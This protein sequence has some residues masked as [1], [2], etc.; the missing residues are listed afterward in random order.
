MRLPVFG[1]VAIVAL[2]AGC[3]K[4]ALTPDAGGSI[5]GNLGLGGAGIGGDLGLGGAGGGGNIGPGGSAST[6]TRK[7]DILFVIDDS[8]LMRLPQNNLL[9]NFPAMASRLMDPP[10]LPDLHLAVISSDMGAGDGSVSGCDS[11]GGKNGIFQYTARG[12]C[13]ATGLAPGATYISDNGTVRNY[14]GNLPDVFACIAALGESGCGFEHPLAAIA[15][16]LGADGRPPPAENQGFLRPDAY[17][18]IVLL[19]NE[20]DCSAPSGSPLFDTRSSTNLASV[21]GPLQNFRCNEFGH[22]CNGA[23]P[24][25]LAPNGSVDD[26]VAMDGCVPAEGNGVLIPVASFVAQL[27]SLKAFPD[28]Q[29]VVSAIAGPAVPYGVKWFGPPLNDTGPWPVMSHSCTASDGSVADPAVRVESWVRS[30][31]A[32]GL[33]LPVC[34]DS[35]ASSFDRIA[36][37]LNTPVG[38][39]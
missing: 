3:G 17:L 33:I 2:A 5:G 26:T 9:R 28:Q 37:L 30:F 38:T 13:T 1:L 23:R 39:Q 34:L 10:G 16:A 27:R 15:R 4:R 19:T 36:Q 35:F 25:R 12:T 18:F 7:L 8:S 24:P 20:D 31:G 32:N 11:T 29:I 22:L 14:T 6:P 21:L